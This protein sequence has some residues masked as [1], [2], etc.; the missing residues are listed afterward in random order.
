[1]ELLLEYVRGVERQIAEASEAFQKNKL[2]R[3]E[4]DSREAVIE[5]R[6][7]D[8][9]TWDLRSVFEEYFPNLQRRGALISICC[10]LEDEL[11][12]LCQ[13]FIK[14]EDLKVSLGDINHKG[15]HRALLFLEKIVGL[16]LDKGTALWQEVRNIQA[17]RNQI[18]H[19]DGKLAEP[20]N[21]KKDALARYV[22]Q[23][24]YLTGDTEIMILNGYLSHVID[25]FR[26]QF[27]QVDQAI[28]TRV[29]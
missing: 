18:V 5:Y 11:N 10:F 19:V 7:L 6:G 9:T 8:D 25:T 21:G 26:W 16:E 29:G 24:T 3:I 28:K 1:M 13:L 22:E 12:Q 27:Q 4:E 20:I 23:S 15:L 17:V 14:T 2:I